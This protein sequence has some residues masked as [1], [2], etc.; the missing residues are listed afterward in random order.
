MTNKE[1]LSYE[2]RME[3][4]EREV[5][6]H[7]SNAQMLEEQLKKKIETEHALASQV[8]ML[9]GQLAASATNTTEATAAYQRK[10]ETL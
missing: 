2:E 6:A 1:R 10:C 4:C 3:R 5:S 8:S 9:A 7:R